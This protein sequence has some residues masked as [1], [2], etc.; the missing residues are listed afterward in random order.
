MNSF[1][2]TINRRNTGSVKWDFMEQKLGLEGSD[3]LPM[4]VSDY[5]FQAP[6]QVLDRLAQD[7]AHGIFGYSERQ[8]DYYQAVIDWFKNQHLS[9]IHI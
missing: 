4:W 8:D 3:L 5:D 7:I 1:D 2:N 6:Q 9:L